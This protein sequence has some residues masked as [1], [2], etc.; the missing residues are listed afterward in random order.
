MRNLFVAVVAAF[1]LTSILPAGA[2]DLKSTSWSAFG[3]SFKVP[4]DVTVEDDSEEGYV[5]SNET[6]YISVQILDGESMNKDA[7]ANEI[8]QLA[9]EDQLNDQTPVKQFDLPQFHGVQLQGTS[10]GEYY[11]YS[12]L[13]S[14][15]ESGGIFVTLIYKDKA[16]G[17]PCDIINSFQ[18]DE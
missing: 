13:M 16:D 2:Q 18:L 17:I 14:K 6:Y 12:Y 10:E 1:C 8:K 9:T 11:L 3:V 5:L 15:D 4:T 7:M